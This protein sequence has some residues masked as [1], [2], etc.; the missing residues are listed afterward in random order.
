MHIHFIGI[1]GTFMAGL[2]RLAH[3]LGHQVSGCDRDF[4][5]PMSEEIKK[6]D[7]KVWKGFDKDIWEEVN[8]DLVVVGNVASR[9]M[10][11]IESM[12]KRRLPFTH[13]AAWLGELTQNR[14]MLAVAGTHGKTTTT[15]MLIHILQKQGIDTGYVLGGVAHGLPTSAHLGTHACFVVEADE[16]DSAYFDKRPKFMHYHPQVFIVNNV[17][18][19]HADIYEYVGQIEN[20]FAYGARLVPPDGTVIFG[21]D[22]Q[23]VLQKG[24]WFNVINLKDYRL[25]P[26]GA[27]YLP[28]DTFYPIPASILGAHNRENALTAALAASLLA[29]PVAD[30]LQAL[31]D[32]SGVKRRLECVYDAA[33]ILVFDDFAHHPTAIAKTL[34]AVRERYPNNRLWVALEPRSNSMKAGAHKAAL[35]DALQQADI[36]LLYL[37]DNATWTLDS[38][39]IT[40]IQDFEV[41]VNKLSDELRAGDVLVMMSNGGFSGLKSTLISRLEAKNNA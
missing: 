38:S 18:F 22:S 31:A 2:A 13:G 21:K 35:P 3:A 14:T 19:D 33:G 5:P 32:F 39:H 36:A 12:L 17:E 15:A 11:I 10:P 20:Q 1:C 24:A 16:Y 6:L 30:G 40:R 7:I 9:G 25:M 41:L 26:T 23:T 37:P 8:P 29:I 4:Y 34:A 28:D 27:V